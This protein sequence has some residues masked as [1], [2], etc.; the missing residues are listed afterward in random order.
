MVEEKKDNNNKRG[1]NK[2]GRGR[3]RDNRADA[4]FDQKIIDLARVTRVMA[5]G[6]RMRF[7]ACMAI[8]DKNGKIAIAVAK[9]A[10]VT[11]AITK[12]VNKAKKNFV[13][14]P[15]VGDSTIPH[16]IRHKFKAARVMIKPAPKGTGVKAG[17][18]MRS[19]FEL[20][21]IGNVV[22]KIMGSKNKIN[23]AQATLKGL[24]SIETD[25]KKKHGTPDKQPEGKTDV[26][27]EKVEDTKN[28]KK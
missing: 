14:V 25:E 26:G 21:G 16:E 13:T 20:A 27:L 28:N 2:K 1:N 4:E 15:I 7:R 19:V 17:G 5:G 22:G 3:G 23:I 12:A 6:K 9:G 11:I 8:G 10:D 18:V 24:R